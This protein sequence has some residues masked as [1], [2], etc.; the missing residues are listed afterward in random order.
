MMLSRSLRLIALALAMAVAASAGAQVPMPPAP[1]GAAPPAAAT[2]IFAPGQLDQMLA[3]IAL[4]PDPLLTAILTAATYP[5]EVVEADRWVQSGANA[6]LRGD[7]LVEALQAQD[8]DPSVKSLV[9][10][11]EILAMMDQHLDWTQNLGNAFLA[12][13]ADVMASIERLR[14]AASATGALRSTAQ[15]TVTQDGPYTDIEPTNPGQLYIPVYPASVYG[16]WPDPS[17]PPVFWAPP[18]LAIGATVGGIAFGVGIGIVDA[19]WNWGDWDWRNHD[20]RINAS[21]FNRINAGHPAVTSNEWRHDPAH[22]HGVPYGDAASR[23]RY[24]T[25]LTGSASARREFRGYAP[26]AAAPAA[27]AAALPAAR[28][29]E[30]GQRQRP[31]ATGRAPTTAPQ[32]PAAAAPTPRAATA[33]TP[34]AAPSARPT[35]A[36]PS[37][38]A[39]PA[40]VAVPPRPAPAPPRPAAAPAPATAFHAPVNGAEVRAQAARGAASRQAMVARPPAAP[41]PA[42]HAPA[43]ARPA[44]APAQRGKP[45]G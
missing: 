18:G 8:W 41:A 39:V 6:S 45:H 38:P 42:A 7:Q 35:I 30:A 17:Y 28:S 5:L 23:A 44:P 26:Q 1:P 13:Q 4:Y 10:F 29:R 11:P 33:P 34:R 16:A 2:S 31:A 9:P 20:I 32:R 43:A 36:A 37:H 25:P 22:R 19:L 15:V 3:S 12:Q 24:E 14:Q 27:A 21:R 40:Q